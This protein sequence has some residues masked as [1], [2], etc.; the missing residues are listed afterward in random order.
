MIP[1]NY[2]ERPTSLQ[3]VGTHLLPEGRHGLHHLKLPLNSWWELALLQDDIDIFLQDTS[4]TGIVPDANC[5]MRVLGPA[6]P[7]QCK[8]Q[9]DSCDVLL[10]P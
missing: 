5:I 8:W 10:A 1:N 4:R 2:A 3:T 9:C 7:G 6:P